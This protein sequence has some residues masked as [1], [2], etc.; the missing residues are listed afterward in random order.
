VAL[1]ALALASAA[2]GWSCQRGEAAP[3]RRPSSAADAIR[4]VRL[5]QSTASDLEQRFGVP[6]ERAPDG[7]LVYRFESPRE[8]GGRMQAE[9]ETVTFRFAG[10]K[11]AQ[12]CRRRS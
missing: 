8:H 6:D 10:G 3:D 5:G 4:Q 9:A 12:V 11:L 7:A 1:I 2:G